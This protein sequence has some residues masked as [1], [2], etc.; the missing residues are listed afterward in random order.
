MSTMLLIV[1]Y[2]AFM[3]MGVPDSLFGAAWS[4]IYREF[5]VPIGWASY[6]TVI[7]AIGTVISSLNA[8]KVIYRFGTANVTLVSTAMTAASI[9]GFACSHRFIWLCICSVPI[10]FGA[11]AVDAALNNYVALHYKA[12]HMNFMQCCYGIGV[13]VSPYLMSLALSKAS[14]WNQGYF[15]TFWLQA[16]ITMVVLCSLPLWRKEER[17]AR[18]G[19]EGEGQ[20]QVPVPLAELIKDR[21]IRT[22][23]IMCFATCGLEFICA[24]WGSTFLV[25]E[26]NMTVDMGARFIISYYIGVTVGR[27]LAGL[28]AD[29][30]KS[31]NVIKIAEGVTCAGILFLFVPSA[32]FSVI[33]L[34][35]LGFNA[36]LAPNILYL[37]PDSF[38]EEISQSVTGL[39]MAAMYVGVLEL[40]ACFGLL[41]KIMPISIYPVYVAAV[42]AVLVWS[43]LHLRKGLRHK[44]VVTSVK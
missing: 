22:A 26:R 32:V 31:W 10:G 40:P 16:G 3:G 23:C 28:I 15:M 6:I 20:K 8:A 19:E 36:I 11:G 24:G 35:L 25:E 44:P 30:L 9:L 27:F 41:T 14:D 18:P 29:R 5:G 4:A 42:A 7:I 17:A 13:S 39:E 21:N 1:I 38:G 37:A 2:I 12:S 33:G 43:T 34:F